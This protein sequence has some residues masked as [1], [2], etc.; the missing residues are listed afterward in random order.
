MCIKWKSRLRSEEKDISKTRL[1]KSQVLKE[2]DLFNL[3]R[4]LAEHPII[5]RNYIPLI[6]SPDGT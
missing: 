5:P 4:E 6:R 3:K 1:K 2:I